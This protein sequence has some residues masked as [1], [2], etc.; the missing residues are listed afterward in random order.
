MVPANPA[1]NPSVFISYSQDSTDHSAKVLALADWLRSKGVDASIDQYEQNPVEGWPHWT[2]KQIGSSDFVVVVCTQPYRRRVEKKESIGV[3]LGATWEGQLIYNCLYEAQGVNNK[4]VPVLIS[5]NDKAGIPG[6]LAQSQHYLV[7]REERYW[8]LYRALTHQPLVDKPELGT[9]ISLPARN[10]KIAMPSSPVEI[11]SS[12]SFSRGFPPRPVNEI[13]R[14][15]IVN[16][17]KT[18]AASVRFVVVEG[19]EGAGKTTL[20]SQIARRFCD[21]T[22]SVFLSSDDRASF[23]RETIAETLAYQFY[24]LLHESPRPHG[25]ADLAEVQGYAEE[26]RRLSRRSGKKFMIIIDGLSEVG[27]LLPGGPK[28]ILEIFPQLGLD[29]FTF[30]VSGDLGDL[31]PAIGR[32]IKAKS[33]PVIDFGIEDSIHFFEGV[34]DQRELLARL[35]HASEGLP[36]RLAS[37]RRLIISGVSVESHTREH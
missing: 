12:I 14:D 33:F 37:L 35:H 23:D 32:A 17:L 27:A 34:V 11:A 20:L 10:R 5:E 4:F 19:A 28:S 3:G 9:I 15:N 36:A 16:T 7:D 30:V 22:A 18:Q 1:R 31:Q 29:A 8:D 25:R 13:P 2:Q 6:P 24:W 21:T 26:L